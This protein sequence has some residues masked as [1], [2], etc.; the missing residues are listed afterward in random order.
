[1]RVSATRN[2]LRCAA[3]ETPMSRTRAARASYCADSSS[4]RPK[5]L[6]SSA[7]ATLNRSVIRAPSSAFNVICSRV[8]PARRRPR[9]RVGS[10]NNGTRTRAASVSCHDKDVIATS[11]TTRLTA[12]LTTVD[13]VVV[14][15]CCAPT[16]SELMRVTRA[17]VCARVK[18]AMGWASTWRNTSARRSKMRPSPRRADSQRCVIVTPA[19]STATSATASES[20]TTTSRCRGTTPSSMMCL[21]S[22]GDATTMTAS[23]TTRTRNAAIVRR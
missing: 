4:G 18:N 14:N 10:R 5:S 8:R 11:S 6:T 20:H 2:M 23:S 17:P 15:A 19:L 12:L 22:S 7:P 13:N 1:M 21:S 9:K 16:T 3:I